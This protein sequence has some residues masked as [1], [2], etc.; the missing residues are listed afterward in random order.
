MRPSRKNFLSGRD[1]FTGLH[2]ATDKNA[3]KRSGQF[4]IFQLYL[5]Q[6]QSGFGSLN[7][8]FGSCHLTFNGLDFF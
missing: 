6:F 8:G 3:F 4:R 1:D 5:G 7:L 2:I